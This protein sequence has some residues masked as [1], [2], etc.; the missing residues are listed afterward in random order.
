MTKW[1]AALALVLP[2]VVSMMAPLAGAA[3]VELNGVLT[4]GALIVGT[5]VPGSTVS[6]DGTAVSVDPER[7]IFVFGIER[8]ATALSLVVVEPDGQREVQ[9]LAVEP[10]SYDIERIDG[11]PPRKVTPNDTDV[12]RIQREG[13]L[14]HAARARDGDEDWF[15]GGFSWPVL[16]RISGRYGNQRVL[17]GEPRSPHLG[18]DI[19]APTGTPV[20]ASA[21]GRV[22]LAESDLFYTGGTVVLDHGHG[23][24]SIYSHL[25]DVSV[26]VGATVVRGYKL[27]TV[28]ATGRATGPHLDWRINWFQ[29]RLDPALIAGPPPTP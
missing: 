6:V 12:A 23:V 1:Q 20:V 29:T 27:G 7:G 25:Q 18:I 21:S 2:W 10:R 26:A 13:A 15:L 17:N 5:T 24:T 14:I 22:S 11:L 3:A 9:D 28:G 16:G 4:Q 19:A 8:D